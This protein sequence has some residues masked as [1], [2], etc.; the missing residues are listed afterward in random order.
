MREATTD[1]LTPHELTSGNA[2]RKGLAVA[3]QYPRAVIL[4]A[5]TL[6]AFEGATIGKPADLAEA[7]RILAGLSGR[8][9][10]VATGVCVAQLA[11]GRVATFSVRSRV[12]FHEWDAAQIE[13]YLA[14]IN[15]LDKA[16]AYA[17]QG[18]GAAIVRRIIGSRTNVIGLP[19]EKV[20]QVL[21]SFGI[22]PLA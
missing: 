2:L 3:R 10:T 18:R 19:M 12:F 9:H 5:D 20:T 8:E 17:A 1:A 16:G 13:R 21:A 11:R 14:R 6:V 7:R 4:A 22:E 15:P